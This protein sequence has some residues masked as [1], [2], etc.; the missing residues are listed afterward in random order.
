[1]IA[2]AGSSPKSQYIHGN[3]VWT[4]ALLDGKWVITSFT[5][6]VCYRA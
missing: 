4:F 2:P 5:Y 3:E 6:N 1:M